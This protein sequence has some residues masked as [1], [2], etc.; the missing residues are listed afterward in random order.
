M[1]DRVQIDPAELGSR[2]KHA[3]HKARLSLLEVESQTGVD[4]SQQSR[5]ERGEFKLYGQNVQKLCEFFDLQPIPREIDILRARLDRALL[6]TPTRK[7]LEAVL[8]AIEI[9]HPVNREKL[10]RI[11]S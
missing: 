6:R 4:H 5:I 10:V 1:I 7:A 3:R 9:S 11:Q 8:D 2:I